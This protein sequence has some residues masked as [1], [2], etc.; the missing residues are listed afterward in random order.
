MVA[1]RISGSD[2]SPVYPDKSAQFSLK[3]GAVYLESADW[4]S[5]TRAFRK[6]IAIEPNCG[7]G[8]HG[9]GVAL[10]NQGLWSLAADAHRRAEELLPDDVETLYNLGVAYGE[11]AR[12]EAAESYFRRVLAARPSD[13]ETLIRLGVEVASQ[14]RHDEAVAVFDAALEI[15]P[16]GDLAT[17]A[18][19]FRAASLVSLNR[20]GEARVALVHACALTPSLLTDRHDAAYLWA[21]LERA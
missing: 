17:D 14:D 18:L 10:G 3:E 15:E 8:Y 2:V 11:L 7:A 12:P 16:M 4:A 13:V 6:A 20:L 19:V 9:L 5:A 1:R 21:E